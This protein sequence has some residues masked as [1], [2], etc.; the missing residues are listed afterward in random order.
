MNAFRPHPARTAGEV[1]D[2]IDLLCSKADVLGERYV[3][4]MLSEAVV[5][6]ERCQFCGR[7]VPVSCDVPPSDYC[8]VSQEFEASNG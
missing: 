6:L 4:R 5:E 8:D 2:Y 1:Q 3:A 7:E